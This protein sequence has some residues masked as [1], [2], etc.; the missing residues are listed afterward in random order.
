MLCND[1]HLHLIIAQA[2]SSSLQGTCD[3]FK[4]CL[5]DRIYELNAHEHR[6]KVT[7]IS[8]KLWIF[9]ELLVSEMGACQ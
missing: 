9:F 1:L 4:S 5:K 6:H 3:A 7:V 8:G 2:L